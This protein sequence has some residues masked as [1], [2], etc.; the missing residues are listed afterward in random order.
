MANSNRESN[1]ARGNAN[2]VTGGDGAELSPGS[3]S[4]KTGELFTRTPFCKLRPHSMKLN[5]TLKIDINSHKCPEY[6]DSN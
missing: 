3:S 4:L 6:L 2:R 5:R 1:A